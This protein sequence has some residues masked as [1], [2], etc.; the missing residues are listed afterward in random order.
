MK[1]MKISRNS[2]LIEKGQRKSRVKYFT[3]LL[4]FMTIFSLAIFK[5]AF[6]GSIFDRAKE[7]GLDQ[8]GTDAYGQSDSPTDIRV[9]IVNG[10]IVF[11]SILSL[12]FLAY[13]LWA[14]FQ[15]MMAGGDA[16]AVNT[17]KK[18]IINAV[19]GLLIV[20]A[21]WGITFFVSKIILNI[22]GSTFY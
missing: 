1:N 15:W 11:L 18:Q 14:G 22:T 20:L 3:I 7:G 12:I 6:A 13:I 8:I 19:F 2:Y 4:L 10:I 21:S 16:E 17:A 5:D 9:I